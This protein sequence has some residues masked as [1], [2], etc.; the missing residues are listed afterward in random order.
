MFLVAS[1]C[2]K[3][4][5]LFPGR[6]EALR[7]ARRGAA[8]FFLVL[9]RGSEAQAQDSDHKVVG[10]CGWGCVLCLVV[11]G[12][13]PLGWS[14]GWL[15][16]RVVGPTGAEV[17]R[18]PTHF[19]FGSSGIPGGTAAGGGDGGPTGEKGGGGGNLGGDSFWLKQSI[20]GPDFG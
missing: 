1:L 6:L 18:C 13:L 17:L 9:E 2:S 10:G 12:C 15:L 11:F 16:G 3:R 8:A 7:G 5:L 19:P 20:R 4:F 14:V